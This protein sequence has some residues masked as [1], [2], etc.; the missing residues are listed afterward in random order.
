MA[1]AQLSGGDGF[2]D[3]RKST[4]TNRNSALNLEATPLNY[5]DITK[6]RA[7]LTAIGAPYNTGGRLDAMTLNDMI[8]ALRTVDDAA[9]I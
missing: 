4:A 3:K 7:R 9:G 2:I 5:V 6:L 8:Y 1:N